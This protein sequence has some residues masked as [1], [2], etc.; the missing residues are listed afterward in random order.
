M[1]INTVKGTVVH[2]QTR[3]VGHTYRVGDCTLDSRHSEKDR[4]TGI[5][6]RPLNRTAQCDAVA[7]H[8]NAIIGYIRR[9]REVRAET[10]VGTLQLILMSYVLKRMLGKKWKGCRKKSQ[11]LFRGWR[12]C[13]TVTAQFV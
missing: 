7:N 2:L 8:A 13:L 4:G 10:D 6:D 3:N 12:R 9:N 1:H 5:V 11:K